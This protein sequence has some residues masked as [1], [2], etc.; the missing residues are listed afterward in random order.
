MPFDLTEDQ[1]GV[2]GHLLLLVATAPA[3]VGLAAM[4]RSRVDATLATLPD[5]QRDVLVARFGLA[6][7]RPRTR[8]HLGKEWGLTTERI[9]RVEQDA[10]Q[11][12]STAARWTNRN[13]SYPP[14][15]DR[16]V[17]PPAGSSASGART[18]TP[19]GRPTG[20]SARRSPAPAGR[21]T[22][23]VIS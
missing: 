19:P 11:A 5:R 10:L 22:A 4:L 3:D 15:R 14:A 8:P 9:R 20:S 23:G 13:A 16:A 12:F 2:L 1:R 6:D 21:R 17:S 7:G 18:W